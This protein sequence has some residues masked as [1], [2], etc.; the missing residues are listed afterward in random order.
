VLLAHEATVFG[1]CSD[2]A[3]GGGPAAHS[4]LGFGF[5][6]HDAVG[7]WEPLACGLARRQAH[8]LKNS[9]TADLY[10]KHTRVLTFQNFC[11]VTATVLEEEEE[12]EEERERSFI[13][14]HK[15]AE[16]R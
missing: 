16:G 9:S 3:C 12:E 1:G 7:L 15:V 13:D 10:S 11:L 14:N 6:T 8:I 5:W 2:V 4:G